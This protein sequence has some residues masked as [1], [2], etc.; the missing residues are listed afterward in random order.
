MFSITIDRD[1][2]GRHVTKIT[3]TVEDE[4]LAKLPALLAELAASMKA[5]RPDADRD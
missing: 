4:A 3:I 5:A 1:A 2:A